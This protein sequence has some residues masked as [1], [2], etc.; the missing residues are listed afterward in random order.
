MSKQTS[1]ALGR[2]WSYWMSVP[3][4][5]QILVGMILGITV[6]VVFGEQATV[7]KPIGTLFVNIIKMLIVPL[8]FCSLIVG[9]TSMEDTAKM[10]RI[11]FKSFAFYL[12]TTAIAISI[13]LVV[14]YVIQPGAG[15]NLPLPSGMSDVVKEVPSVMQTLLDIVPTNPIAALANGQILQV[16]VFAVALGIALVLIGDHGKPAI[17][18]FESLAEAMYK[19]TDMVMKLAPYGVFGLM[20]WVAGEYGIEMLLP[21]LKVIVAVYI[22]CIIHVLGFYSIVLSVFSKLNPL[23][24]FK[25]ISNAIAV[26]FTTSSS[27]GTL[28]ASMKCASEYLGVNKKI[29]SFVLPLGTTINMDGT[30]LYQGVTALFVAQAFGIDLTWVDYLTII[31]TATLASIGT[32][33]VPGAGLVMLTLVLSTVGLPLEGVALIAGIDRILDMARTVVNVSGD[34]VATTVIAKSEHELDMEHY[35]ADMVQSA[36]LAE[37]NIILENTAAKT[38]KS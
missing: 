13:G 12:C 22:G 35:N 17:K 2:V 16:I 18:V 11:G 7:L 3:L 32:A 30:A 24:F 5:L 37:Q 8:V 19:L 33:G 14:G 4:W 28:P 1:S 27:A 31:L 6:G 25:G 34:L 10:G 26:A 23:H 15:L 21:L 20:A 9:V 38:V 36:V 29:S